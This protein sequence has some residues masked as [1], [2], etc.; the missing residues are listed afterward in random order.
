VRTPG[1]SVLAVLTAVLCAGGEV[2]AAGG[3]SS[4]AE[5]LRVAMGARAAGLGESFTGL[6]DDVTAAAW[7]PAGL[8]QLDGPQFSA[9][10]LAWFADV[11]Y[12]YLAACYPTGSSGM[13]ALSG[14]YVNVP[15]FDSTA[16]GSGEAKG[17]ASDGMVALSW[18]G[19]FAAFA[20]EEPGLAGLFYGVTAKV[21]YRSLGGYAPD[22]GSAQS[23]TAIAEAADIGFLYK[24]GGAFSLG[25][26]VMNLGGTV[27]FLK[28]EADAMPMTARGGVGL[29]V[30][31]QKDVRVVVLADVAKPVDPDGGK[32]TA[33]TWGGGGLEVT[34]FGIV[35]LRG[36]YR[37]GPDGGRAV[38]GAGF[39]LGPV[40]V[41]AAVVP[42]GDFGTTWR[43]GVTLK[44]GIAEKRLP[45]VTDLAVEGLP[46]GKALVKWTPVYGAIGYHVDVLTPTGTEFIRVTKI[47]REAPEMTLAK[48]KG[49][50]RYRFQ[51]VAVSESGLE[52]EL[53][54]AEWLTPAETAAFPAAPA[55]VDAKIGAPGQVVLTWTQVRG[56]TG[57]NVYFRPAGG[58]W[59][60]ATKTP[61]AKLTMTLKEL[62]GGPT[63]FRVEPAGPGGKKG[64][65]RET[66]MM[67]PSAGLDSW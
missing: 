57:Y 46:G 19:S 28:D 47:P 16:A 52:G 10:H 50:S 64:K 11:S 25:V 32:F 48:L 38:G 41:D 61:T 6:A 15:P 58:K 30:L 27:T 40:S 23:Y 56:S 17:T 43:A 59:K 44:F 55:R 34:A 39:A 51:V 3:G 49:D 60:K 21:V 5:F 67:V 42:M 54:D 4:G 22:G 65:T 62:Q 66:M 63:E 29:K 9:M 12:E 35:S 45:A 8:G 33:G 24:P 14:A 13:I 37:L 26:S 18:G 36:G 2:R 20:P 31:D 1:R 7:N 53:A